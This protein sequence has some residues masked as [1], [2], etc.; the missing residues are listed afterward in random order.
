MRVPI[1]FG[2]SLWLVVVAATAAT[3]GEP[4]LRALLVGVSDYPKETVGDLQLAGPK[5]DV[6]LMLDT[7]GR[8]G[9]RAE[10]VTVLADGL[11]T[12]T[13]RRPVTY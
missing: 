10:D 8:L 3:A 1:L 6:A 5:N 7:L 13:A 12:T 4:R 2:L 11:E 9:F